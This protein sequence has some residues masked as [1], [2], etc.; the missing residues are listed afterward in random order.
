MAANNRES[1]TKPAYFRKGRGTISPMRKNHGSASGFRMLRLAI[2]LLALPAC[3]ELDDEGGSNPTPAGP[4][5]SK[6]YWTHGNSESPLMRPGGTCIQCH[7]DSREGPRFAVAGTLYEGLT[8]VSDCNGKD[9]RNTDLKV[10]ITDANNKVVTLGVNAAGN[11]YYQ[12]VI[13]TPYKAKVV[14]AAGEVEMVKPQTIGECNSCHAA[15]GLMDAPGRI[16]GP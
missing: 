6:T 5:A 16:V 12:G 10:V 9:G 7:T 14:S 3:G 8:D 15:K 1:P 2:S 11:F 4:C 13:A